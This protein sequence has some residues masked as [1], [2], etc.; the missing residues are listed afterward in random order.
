VF[1][2]GDVR[3]VPYDYDEK[4][5]P[6]RNLETALSVDDFLKNYYGYVAAKY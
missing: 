1:S 3:R 6:V 2:W 4:G 5:M